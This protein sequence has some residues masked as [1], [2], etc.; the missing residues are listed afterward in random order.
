MKKNQKE[1]PIYIEHQEL[2]EEYE[3]VNLLDLYK[4]SFKLQSIDLPKEYE[5]KMPLLRDLYPPIK[6][7]L[8]RR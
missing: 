4:D 6:R 3:L 2:K 8:K 5:E 1:E 7:T